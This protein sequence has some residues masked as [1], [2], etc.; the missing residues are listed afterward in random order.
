MRRRNELQKSV[1]SHGFCL[2]VPERLQLSTLETMCR[3]YLLD[4]L[5]D[6]DKS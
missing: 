3:V 1:K 6:S 5:D 4:S 2:L